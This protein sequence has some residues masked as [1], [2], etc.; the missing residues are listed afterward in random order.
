[1]EEVRQWDDGRHGVVGRHW[2]EVRHGGVGRNG[3]EAW[4]LGEAQ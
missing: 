4:G 2:D 3:D 1:M